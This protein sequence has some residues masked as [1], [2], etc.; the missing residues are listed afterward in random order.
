MR[1][2]PD[3]AADRRPGGPNGARAM[4]FG[5]W[6]I[7]L[8][9]LVGVIIFGAGKLPTVMG[10]LGKGIKNFK[11]SLDGSADASAVKP[12]DERTPPSA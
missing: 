3:R 5:I 12:S 1:A 6:E 8:I 2:L 7:L 10:D 9:L 4:N 11:S